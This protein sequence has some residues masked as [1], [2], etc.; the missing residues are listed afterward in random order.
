MRE[1]VEDVL[2]GEVDVLPVVGVVAVA[3]QNRVR[4]ALGRRTE[5]REVLDLGIAVREHLAEHGRSHG[6]AVLPATDI[7]FVD[8]AEDLAIVLVVLI[9]GELAVEIEPE[10][11]AACD[12]E[13]E[14]HDVDERVELLAVESA[15]GDLE[16]GAHGYCTTGFSEM[17]LPSSMR[18]VRSL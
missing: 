12:R 13:P 3:Y 11:D 1:D 17:I 8:D 15:P 16:V 6:E 10:H 7:E 2:V 9:V 14:T 18:T 5:A 4:V